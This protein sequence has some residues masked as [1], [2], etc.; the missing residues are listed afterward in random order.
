MSDCTRSGRGKS[1]RGRGSVRRKS[2]MLT[3]M[4]LKSGATPLWMA[5]AAA[6]RRRRSQMSAGCPVSEPACKAQSAAQGRPRNRAAC[7]PDPNCGRRVEMLAGRPA[8]RPKCNS[9]LHTKQSGP[10]TRPLLNL[11][12]PQPCPQAH[13]RPLSLWG[14]RRLCQS[15][16]AGTVCSS[17]LGPNTAARLSIYD[18]R[19]SRKPGQ[20]N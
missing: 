14:L 5:S 9:G 18:P 3:G 15:T 16:A 20:G 13:P 11:S 6:S 1:K 17:G 7:P 2:C 10:P 8:R 4:H 12:T 19:H